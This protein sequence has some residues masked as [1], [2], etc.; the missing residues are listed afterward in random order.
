MNTREAIEAASVH[1]HGM[2]GTKFPVLTVAKPETLDEAV[3]LAK[4]VSK[5]SPILG[6]L[7][8]FRTVLSLNRSPAFSDIEG[9]W[10]RQD[11]GFPDAI[12]IGEIDPPPGFEIKA[13]FPLATEITARFKDS[14]RRFSQDNIDV[15]LLAWLPDRLIYGVPVLI[16]CCIVSGH[17]VAAAR[18]RHYHRPPDYLVV[19]PEDTAARTRNLQQSNTSGYKWQGDADQL[20]VAE[21]VVGA[22]GASGRTY[23][24][25]P[26]YQALLRDL[27]GQFKYRLDT[28]FAKMDRI[29][30]DEI[31][32]FKTRVL[33]SSFQGLSISL[34]AKMIT[35]ANREMKARVESGRASAPGPAERQFRREISSR[36]GVGQ[37]GN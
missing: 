17:S 29:E 6:N 31:E 9:E 5:L 11:P 15:V 18:D 8:E 28:N 1:L 13:W 33:S 26:E 7:I 2:A 35:Q 25:A 12:F 34:W 3:N 20:Q 4:I 21:S 32:D 22:W 16:D 10:R 19:E 24:P 37:S 27:Q 14:Q 36:L 30:H 23:D